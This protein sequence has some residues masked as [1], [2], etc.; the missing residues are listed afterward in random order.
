M[1]KDDP[2]II[3]TRFAP[4]PSGHLHVGGARTALFCWVYAKK[5]GGRFVLRI[6]DTDQKRSSDAASM[7]FL[8][9]LKW[10][11]IEWDEGPE[12]EGLGGRPR[13][14]DLPQATPY[15]QSQR[16]ELYNRHFEQ[17][18]AEGKSTIR[19]TIFENRFMHVPELKRLGARIEVHGNLAVIEGPT[20]L[21][22]APIMATDLRASAS[23]VVAGLCAQG[24]TKVSRIY[25]LDRGY[26][27]LDEKLRG[28]GVDVTRVAE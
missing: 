18:I 4:S 16:L 20:L 28:L 12:F 22:G 23:L 8:E 2:A 17:L 6:E 19:E 25:H 3:R 13:G 21:Q 24:Q 14:A 9:D 5:H 10:L 1:S 26:Q 27:R 11:G 15:F 7:A